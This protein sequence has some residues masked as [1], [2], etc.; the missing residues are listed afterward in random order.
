M[1][2]IRPAAGSVDRRTGVGMVD[3]P[4]IGVPQTHFSA[5]FCT[6]WHG[7]LLPLAC[8]PHVFSICVH[9]SCQGESKEQGLWSTVRDMEI[10]ENGDA[11]GG[12]CEGVRE[13]N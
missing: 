11:G 5:L 2:D 10:R 6:R 7:V 8:Y 4:L 1:V 3:G 9:E 12:D 13:K